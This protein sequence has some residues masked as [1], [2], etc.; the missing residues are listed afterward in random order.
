MKK[1]GF[2]L[3]ELIASLAIC[4]LILVTAYQIFAMTI[5]M[6]KKSYD[7]ELDFKEYSYA[8]LY[9]DNIVRSAYKIDLMD[10]PNKTSNFIAY[11]INPY[12]SNATSSKSKDFEVTAYVF[13]TVDLGDGIYQL[14]A[15]TKNITSSEFTY[16]YE[17]G[18][19]YNGGYA[20]IAKCQSAKITYEEG[21]IVHI[22]LNESSPKFRYETKIYL[23]DRL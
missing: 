21:N 3:I 7:N 10:K 18:N 9:V 5:T 16:N 11:V 14:V 15:K 12:E 17:K 8:C 6:T 13:D 1:R 19:F 22:L 23:G 20:K 4:S 2:T